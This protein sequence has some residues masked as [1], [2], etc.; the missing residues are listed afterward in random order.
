MPDENEPTEITPVAAAFIEAIAFNFE[1]EPWQEYAA[2]K[3][4]GPDV[5]F[6]GRGKSRKLAKATCA[7]CPVQS[8]CS[9]YAD[10]SF[11]EHGIWGGITRKR[12]DAPKRGHRV[13]HLPST[14]PDIEAE[15]GT[16]EAVGD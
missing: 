15:R 11:T 16:T 13:V 4:M 8:E 10:R 5:F 6:P 1:C 2:C 7:R 14:Q 3:N 12:G 9:D